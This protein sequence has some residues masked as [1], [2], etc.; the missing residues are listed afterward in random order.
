[1]DL[2]QFLVT[3]GDPGSEIINEGHISK[4][5]DEVSHAEIEEVQNNK[6]PSLDEQ[7]YN[8]ASPNSSQHI[9]YPSGKYDN[10]SRYN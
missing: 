3:H 2:E 1:M 4:L 9:A 5:L 7:T 8:K 10:H 6:E